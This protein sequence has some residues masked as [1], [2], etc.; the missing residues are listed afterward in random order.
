MTDN[1]FDDLERPFPYYVAV[2]RSLREIFKALFFH[3]IIS[4]TTQIG[5]KKEELGSVLNKKF[6]TYYNMV[7]SMD[8]KG[9]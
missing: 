1:N 4:A 6:W 9:L 5:S 8:G 7:Y 3:P 2:Y